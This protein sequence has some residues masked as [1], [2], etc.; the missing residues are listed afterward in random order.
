MAWTDD[1]VDA[2]KKMWLDGMSASQIANELG[3]VTRNAVIGKV[4]RLGLSGRGKPTAK[5]TTAKS[6]KSRTTQSRA[7]Q[8]SSFQTIGATVLKS[9]PEAVPLRQAK[10]QP[11]KLEVYEGAKR[12]T[13]MELTDQ[14]CRWPIGDPSAKDFHFCGCAASEDSPYCAYHSKIAYNSGSERRKNRRSNAA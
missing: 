9:D 1:R 5:S 2:L 11:R 6:R 7:H 3:G 14:T 4:H 13:I 10:P 12:L 8:A